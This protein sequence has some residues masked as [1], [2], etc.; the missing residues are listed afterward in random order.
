M[1]I[2][3][4]AIV[5]EIDKMTWGSENIWYKSHGGIPLKKIEERFLFKFFLPLNNIR[6]SLLVF[7]ITK[8][9][10]KNFISNFPWKVKEVV[11]DCV[12]EEYIENNNGYLRILPKGKKLISRWYYPVE[13]S[14]NPLVLQIVKY[15]IPSLIVVVGFLWPLMKFIIQKFLINK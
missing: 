9:I 15:I 4:R 8:T 10:D 13:F 12:K 6:K 1:F 2:S 5:K 3:P 7:L 14:K 11:K